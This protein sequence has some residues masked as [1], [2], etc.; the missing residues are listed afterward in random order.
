MLKVSLESSRSNITPKDFFNY[1]KRL[2]EKHDID[3][4]SYITFEE[5]SICHSPKY[6]V[7]D[8]KLWDTPLHEINKYYPYNVHLYLQG[9]YNFILEFYYDNMHFG[10]GYFH[11]AEYK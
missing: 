3:I 2:C 6:S 8:H 11:I 7:E 10:K 9:N 4:T 5:W 1:C